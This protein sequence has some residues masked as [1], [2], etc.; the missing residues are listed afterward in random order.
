MFG[1]NPI[2]PQSVNAH[3]LAVQEIFYTIQGEGPFSG[4][5]A[6]FVRL[7]GC[8]LACVYCDTEFETGMDNMMSPATVTR[9]VMEHFQLAAVVMPPA[10]GP[11][12]VVITGGEP[13]RQ[14]LEV[15]LFDLEAAGVKHVQIETAG[16]LWRDS[17]AH[18]VDSGFL[19]IVCSPKTPRIRPELMDNCWHYKYVLEDGRV[20]LTDGLPLG[21]TQL[22]NIHILDQIIAR[23][24]LRPKVQVWVSPCD[25]HDEAKTKANV[26]LAAATA[27]KYGYRLSL[28]THKLLGLP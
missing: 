21:G 5:P 22:R 10:N 4:C 3:A 13:L 26:Q 7:A 19:T 20:S 15:L 23:P 11:A 16:T 14:N 12:L 1:K 6:V 8:N 2:R 25:A 17:L 18:F 9:Q 27:M 24:P 28:Q